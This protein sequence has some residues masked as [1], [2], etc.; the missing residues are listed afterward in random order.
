MFR[1]MTSA[2]VARPPSC[3]LGSYHSTSPVTHAPPARPTT[4]APGRTRRGAVAHQTL[5][6][7]SLYER[8]CRSARSRRSRSFPVRSGSITAA[9]TRR[10]DGGGFFFTLR[11]SPVPAWMHVRRGTSQSHAPRTSRSC[12]PD[13]SRRHPLI[14]ASRTG[15]PWASSDSAM[16]SAWSTSH[17]P[18]CRTTRRALRLVV[19]ESGQVTLYST[20]TPVPAGW[21]PMAGTLCGVLALTVPVFARSGPVALDV[22]FPGTTEP[23][24]RRSGGNSD[25]VGVGSGLLVFGALA[26]THSFTE[27]CR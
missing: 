26:A 24:A 7:P 19:V 17:V 8:G 12:V 9:A 1:P 11:P 23:S 18:P 20:S 6:S 4:P 27:P 16:S 3:V 22:D 5:I 25:S 13:W 21:S 15:L 14:S 10:G 2:A